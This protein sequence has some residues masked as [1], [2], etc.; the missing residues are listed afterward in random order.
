MYTVNHH[1]TGNQ[2]I[3]FSLFDDNVWILESAKTGV[4]P[5][6]TLRKLFSTSIMAKKYA[7]IWG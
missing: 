5:V 6:L 7:G 1:I 2:F 4:A 3:I